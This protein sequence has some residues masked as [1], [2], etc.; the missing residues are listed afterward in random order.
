[1]KKKYS[2]RVFIGLIFFFLLLEGF[3]SVLSD[4]FALVHPFVYALIGWTSIFSS[5]SDESS[6]IAFAEV[7]SILAI[8]IINVT[9]VFM[10]SKY[11]YLKAIFFFKK[12]DTETVEEGI[13]TDLKSCQLEIAHAINS[14]DDN[15]IVPVKR[16]KMLSF[17]KA[18]EIEVRR[19]FHLE[20]NELQCVWI[21]PATN[22]THKF[23]IACID[24]NI[25]DLF[26]M[27]IL[28]ASALRQSDSRIVV[29]KVKQSVPSSENEQFT[30]VKNF[31]KFRLGFAMLVKKENVFTKSNM[32]EF[33][34]LSSYLLLLGFFNSFISS[35]R[36]VVA[37]KQQAS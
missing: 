2:I 29:E 33:E 26:T 31:G 37:F 3:K 8:L 12:E 10:L 14:I 4:F 23:Q 21:L 13:Q 24:D 18:F 7:M 15:E 32:Q 6:L 19:I 17:M 27:E 35:I 20:E 5:Q 36:R 22:A 16:T 9:G 34:D 1:M 25:D 11:F 30:I 28:V